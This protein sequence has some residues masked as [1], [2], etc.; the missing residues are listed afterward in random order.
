[1]SLISHLRWSPHIPQRCAV[2]LRFATAQN[3]RALTDL[4]PGEPRWPLTPCAYSSRV[5]VCEL[6]SVVST[7]ERALSSIAHARSVFHPRRE[8]PQVKFCRVECLRGTCPRVADPPRALPRCGRRSLDRTTL[9][10]SRRA[11]SRSRVPR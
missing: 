3:L 7:I 11:I 2:C 8:N 4:P 6:Y 1:M 5:C 9:P 10:H